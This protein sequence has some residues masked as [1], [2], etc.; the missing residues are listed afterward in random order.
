MTT[1]I[2]N[3]TQFIVSTKEADNILKLQAF[4]TNE[5]VSFAVDKW[6]N[7][8][9]TT[10]CEK[11]SCVRI[12]KEKAIVASDGYIRVEPR[13]FYQSMPSLR[14]PRCNCFAVDVETPKLPKAYIS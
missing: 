2:K 4:N 14:S 7:P 11:T 9:L 10:S 1:D 13:E 6:P 5:A 12:D 8:C 3:S